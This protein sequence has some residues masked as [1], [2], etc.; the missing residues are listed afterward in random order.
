[1][2]QTPVNVEAV[3]RKVNSVSVVTVCSEISSDPFSPTDSA[4]TIAASRPNV[5]RAL[6]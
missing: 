3:I 2:A 4:A 5:N 1:M 6:T